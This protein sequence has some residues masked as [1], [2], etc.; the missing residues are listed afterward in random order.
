[1]TDTREAVI[2]RLLKNYQSYYNII[3]LEDEQSPIK[4]RCEFIKEVLPQEEPI[5][6][7]M[8]R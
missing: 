8:L 1:M 6:D 5:G 2:A 7:R 4:A 3:P